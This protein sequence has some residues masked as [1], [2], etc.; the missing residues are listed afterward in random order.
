MPHASRTFNNKHL[1]IN[2]KVKF[3]LLICL[4]LSIVSG[5]LSVVLAQSAY[6]KTKEDYSIQ[7]KKYNEARNDYLTKKASFEAFQTA[8]AKKE[9]FESTKKYL[10][11]TNFLLADKLHV[12]KEFGNT[13]NWQNSTFSKGD[14]FNL[15]D[16]ETNYLQNNW[17]DIQKTTALEQLPPIAEELKIRLDTSLLPKADKVIGTYEIA[18]TESTHSNFKDLTQAVSNFANSRATSENTAIV[19]NWQ[20]E[21]DNVNAAVNTNISEA[22]DELDKIKL[23]RKSSRVNR[24]FQLTKSAKDELKRSL[25]LFEEILR[26]I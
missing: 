17:S 22:K 2:R 24:I 26:I 13:I 21:I 18:K 20:T 8:T 16:E 12:L 9:A 23:D 15:L 19:H 10:V 7:L 6:E 3:F 1:T 25:N 4:L 14:M 11:E 5:Q